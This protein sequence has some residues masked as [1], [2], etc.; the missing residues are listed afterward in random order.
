[1]FWQLYNFNINLCWS[2]GLAKRWR[3]LHTKSICF[4]CV[5][6]ICHPKKNQHTK[7]ARVMKHRGHLYDPLTRAK[8]KWRGPSDLTSGAK[9]GSPN[10]ERDVELTQSFPGVFQSLVKF[11]NL[12]CHT[13]TELY[14]EYTQ[15]TLCF[16]FVMKCLVL[17]NQ[18]NQM[19]FWIMR[20]VCAVALNGKKILKKYL[21]WFEKLQK[22]SKFQK[23]QWQIK[24]QGESVR[25][26][27]WHKVTMYFLVVQ[28]II[29][30]EKCRL[31][32]RLC[33]RHLIWI[34]FNLRHKSCE[35]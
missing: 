15:S 4:I 30:D 2:G 24:L 10:D 7:P 19:S 26:Y 21:K 25:K 29:L 5:F 14:K 1:M 33:S 9:R 8:D 6:L 22:I 31:V 17:G 18:V 28:I 23:L 3:P 32:Q 13:W 16:L 11:D 34:Q 12:L 35:K 20:F 27:D